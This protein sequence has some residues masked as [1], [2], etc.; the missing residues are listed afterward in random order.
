[1]FLL[2]T[3]FTPQELE[4]HLVKNCNG[5]HTASNRTCPK[6]VFEKDVQSVRCKMQVSFPE[7]RKIIQDQCSIGAW[8]FLRIFK[9][10]LTN[11]NLQEYRN[12]RAK[13]R[14]VIC[15]NKRKVRHEHVS[16]S[17]A[18]TSMKMCWDMIRKIKGK[19]V[20]HL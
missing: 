16:K 8:R 14:Q 17:N 13:A 3:V 5:D 20:V 19:G 12:K 9:R 10:F 11:A 2:P 4:R 1:M 15:A 6:W 7:A 18:R